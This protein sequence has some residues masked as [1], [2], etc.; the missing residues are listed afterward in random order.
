[1]KYLLLVLLTCCAHTTYKTVG[2]VPLKQ[3]SLPT[4][5]FTNDAVPKALQQTIERSFEYW[6]EAT[7]LDLFFYGGETNISP[8]SGES[9]AIIIVAMKDLQGNML[10]SNFNSVITSRELLV[11]TA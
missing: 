5:V 10:N 6:N 3:C 7:K 9:N 2:E 4:M 8:Y 1:M 11:S